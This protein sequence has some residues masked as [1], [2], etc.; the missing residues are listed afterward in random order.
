MTVFTL[1]FY[2]AMNKFNVIYESD[3][4]ELSNVLS[5]L[6]EEIIKGETEHFGAV[7]QS[8]RL[9]LGDDL[10]NSVFDNVLVAI[11]LG[12]VTKSIKGKNIPVRHRKTLSV[13][14]KFAVNMNT[15]NLQQVKMDYINSITKDHS[16][17]HDYP[18]AAFFNAKFYMHDCILKFILI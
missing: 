6:L 10:D 17:N 7:K 9:M 11:E 5:F 12:G 3:T 15:N 18:L 13:N 1:D 4:L 16:L 8:F 2:K 14:T